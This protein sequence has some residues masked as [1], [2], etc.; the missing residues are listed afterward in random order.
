MV[1][2]KHRHQ[3]FGA[4]YPSLTSPNNVEFL[5]LAADARVHAGWAG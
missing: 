5:D 4:Q 3:A 2:A 1:E